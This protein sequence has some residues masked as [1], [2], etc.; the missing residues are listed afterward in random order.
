[1]KKI[2]WIRNHRTGRL[3][4]NPSILPSIET[5][6]CGM[7]LECKICKDEGAF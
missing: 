7:P 5:H 1:M 2:L 4:I 3:W 6:D